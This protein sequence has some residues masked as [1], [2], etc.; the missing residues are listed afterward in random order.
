MTAVN[1][2]HFS[3][4]AFAGIDGETTALFTEL[5][6]M[7]QSDRAAD[8]WQRRRL[9][10]PGRSVMVILVVLLA[11]IMMIVFDFVVAN[12]LLSEDAGIVWILLA[13]AQFQFLCGALVVV[14]YPL[15]LVFF[16]HISDKKIN[17]HEKLSICLLEI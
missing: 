13:F 9:W 4:T 8:W 3:H 2:T 15:L 6:L 12:F 1:V 5:L 16:L 11:I 17:I 10:R 7:Q 14:L